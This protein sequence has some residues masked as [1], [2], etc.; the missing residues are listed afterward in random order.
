[1]AI[2]EF[3]VEPCVGF[4]GCTGRYRFSI[5]SPNNRKTPTQSFSR[6]LAGYLTKQRRRAGPG[7]SQTSARIVLDIT[8]GGIQ[9]FSTLT[10]I[11]LCPIANSLHPCL[12]HVSRKIHQ[13]G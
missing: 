1:M 10:Q 2:P 6:P 3:Y 9:R 7:V 4:D 12:T 11:Q 13:T 5:S 8:Q